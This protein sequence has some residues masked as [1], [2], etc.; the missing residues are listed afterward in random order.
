MPSANSRSQ[1]LQ[2][3]IPDWTSPYAPESTSDEVTLAKSPQSAMPSLVIRRNGRKLG[4]F[5]IDHGVVLVNREEDR[6]VAIQV[7]DDSGFMPQRPLHEAIVD[8]PLLRMKVSGIGAWGNVL[9]FEAEFASPRPTARLALYF[10]DETALYAVSSALFPG[11]TR[12]LELMGL[13]VTTTGTEEMPRLKDKLEWDERAWGWDHTLDGPYI[14]SPGE[15]PAR[16]KRRTITAAAA[17]GVPAEI[18][19]AVDEVLGIPVKDPFNRRNTTHW[20][21]QHG[22]LSSYEL[23]KLRSWAT[24]VALPDGWEEHW[25]ASISLSAPHAPSLTALRLHDAY[26]D[27][28]ASL[29][30][31]GIPEAAHGVWLLGHRDTYPTWMR[32]SETGLEDDQLSAAVAILVREVKDLDWLVPASRKKHDC[33]L[34]GRAFEPGML[35]AGRVA[36]LGTAKVCHLCLRI[37]MGAPPVTSSPLRE[38]GAA[39]AV[40]EVVR[41][42]GRVIS[43]SMVADLAAEGKTSPENLILLRHAL[44]DT[45]ERGWGKWLAQARVLGEGWRPSRGYISVA[46]DGHPCRSL[47]ER[48]IDDYFSAHGIQ[49]EPEPHYPYDDELNPFG[50]RADWRLADGRFVEAAGLMSTAAYA[51]KMAKKVELA[52]RFGIP[53]L[54]LTEADLPHLRELL[55]PPK[56]SSIP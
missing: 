16:S 21:G 2:R 26:P 40:A 48:I 32:T 30:V 6:S 20:E 53:L 56:Q 37:G 25:Q 3:L 39:A 5:L 19:A 27:W 4:T 43:A 54:V 11:I 13:D 44:P 9:L 10:L 42:A 12:H 50:S 36:Q 17:A 15:S 33:W 49:H 52:H 23:D 7:L 34:C 14:F 29:P 18:A 8:E 45:T 55:P 1:K 47:F 28:W 46:A 38:S 22:V 35:P 41:L 24:D 51:A 31:G